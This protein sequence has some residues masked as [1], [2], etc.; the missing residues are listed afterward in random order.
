MRR[1]H[2]ALV[3][4]VSVVALCVLAGGIWLGRAVPEMPQLSGERATRAYDVA[5]FERLDVRGQ[6]Q[7]AVTRGDAWRVEL[8]YPVELAERVEVLVENRRL[9]LRYSAERGWWS[10]F[11]RREELRMSATIVMPMLDELELAGAPALSFS[12]FSGP[13][14]EI[15]SSGA[16]SIEGRDSRYDEL[17]LELSGA[18]AADLSGVTV[19]DAHLEISGAFRVTLRMAGGDLTGDVS[20][21]SAV[22]Y[23][24]SVR[25]QRIDASGVTRV[26]Q[27]D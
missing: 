11:G 12:G 7:V 19:T 9:T 6:W 3:I 16:S 23:Y 21:A 22:A 27:L 10:D 18:G 13:D 1:S 2:A 15:S 5:D 25:T 14:L 26:Q 17:D 24:G 8:S 4:G 20:G